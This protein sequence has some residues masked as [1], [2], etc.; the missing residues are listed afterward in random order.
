MTSVPIGTWPETASYL[1]SFDFC[2]IIQ[3]AECIS[4]HSVASAMAEIAAK[5][6]KRPRG[7]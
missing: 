2:V 3:C 7:E 4:V 6:D 1:I 5:L